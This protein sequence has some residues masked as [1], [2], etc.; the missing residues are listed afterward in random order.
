[1]EPF[2]GEIKAV[3]FSYA[4]RGYAFCQGQ[5]LSIAQNSALFSLLGV[6]FGGNGQVNFGLPNLGGRVPIGQGQSP[7]TSNYV[8]GQLAGSESVTLTSGQM[9][10]HNHTA[11]TTVTPDAAGLTA[12]TTIHALTAPAAQVAI[13]T[14]NF[15]T[16]GVT[17][18]STPVALKPFGTTGTDTTMAA[19]MAVTTIGGTVS[20]TAQTNVGVAGQNLPVSLL[21][22]YVAVNYIIATD[23]VF[24]SRN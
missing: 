6:A 18:G 23:G 9:P 15:L 16:V 19:G 5:L 10:A 12:T 8:L 1:M 11:V 4:P 20:A 7:G 14:G 3:G 13:P 21:Q 2:I 17:G 22:P 24:P